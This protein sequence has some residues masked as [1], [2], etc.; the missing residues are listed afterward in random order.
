MRKYGLGVCLL[1]LM[2]LFTGCSQKKVIIYDKEKEILETVGSVEITEKDLEDAGHRAYLEIVMPEAIQILVDVEGCTIDEAQEKIVSGQYSIYTSFDSNVYESMKNT[3]EAQEENA[4]FGCAAT[5]LNGHLLAVYSKNTLSD[6]YAN[7]AIA[8]MQPYSSFKPLS[9]YAPAIENRVASWSKGY[10]DSP[11][12]QVENA[13]GSLRDWPANSTGIYTDE[14]ILVN[15]AIKKS[16]NTVAVRCLKDV[17]VLNSIQFLKERFGLS[18]SRE[19]SL[20]YV[21]GE[22]EV[23]GNIGLGYLLVG[24]SPVD[25]AGYYQI[26]ATEGIYTVPTTITEICNTNGDVVY[27]NKTEGT[28]AVNKET[29][30]VMNQL[31]QG[32]VS[33]GGTG[34]EAMCKDFL[35]GGKTGTGEN[36]NWFVGFTPK[37]S[38]AVWHGKELMKNNAA[39]MFSA[40]VS[41]LEHSDD[42]G[43][44]VCGTVKEAVYCSESGMLL[45]GKCRQMDRGYY[46]S[47]D[48]SEICNQH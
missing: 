45:S 42:F 24:V 26:F 11:V 32:V 2:F 36:G 23:L 18:L 22:E 33:I 48:T 47:G 40:I 15:E 43:F 25:M 17:G 31:L 14:I 34:K 12:K 8:K 38:C 39:E 6:E 1:L 16:T 37:Y 20:A 5:D 10:L 35:I 30:Y 7:L 3:F 4:S 27:R 29:A 28:Q 21:S 44:P 41:E 46:I 19:E 9:V 13:D